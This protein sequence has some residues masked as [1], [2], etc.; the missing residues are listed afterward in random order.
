MGIMHPRMGAACAVTSVLFALQAFSDPQTRITAEQD[1]LG[2]Q[3]LSEVRAQVFR[4]FP[5]D[6]PGPSNFEGQAEAFVGR[7]EFYIGRVSKS[8]PIC[9]PMQ[10]DPVKLIAQRA[11]RTNIVIINEHHSSPLD[12]QFIAQILRVLRHQGYTLYAAETFTPYESLRHDEVLG[13]DGWYS[14]EPT[15]ARA[16]R[17]AK[18]L[19][20]KL[21]AY[22]Q[23]QTQK[24][25]GLDG[26]L[27]SK[28]SASAREQ[29]QTDNLMHAIFTEN[30]NAKVVI[31]VGHG[32]VRERVDPTK[33]E[34]AAMAQRL[35]AATG[36]DPLTIS[37]TGCRSPTGSDVIAESYETGVQGQKEFS[38]D[39]YVGHPSPI[40]QDGRPAWRRVAGEK[41][42]AVPAVFLNLTERVI[43]EARPVG[44]ALG[45]V[46]SDRL[47]LYPGE[48]LPLL[49]TP[50]H[51]RVDGFVE[52]G[53]M[54]YPP[55]ILNVK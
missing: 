25:A 33:A 8:L 45:A 13:F 50:G 54:D 48:R 55:V 34:Y 52:A 22:E 38:V 16:V 35:K 5:R 10:A 28:E 47:L 24:A 19:G 20:Y 31:H 21:I 3:M 27:N 53:R 46:P 15:F 23:T 11:R 40:F 32:H 30:P 41:A 4:S 1:S 9:I 17:L 49:L 43:L 18:S 2:Q 6:A 37:Q 7:E 39:L 42:A 14:N 29:S 36:R 44:T 51:Y 12:R 26:S